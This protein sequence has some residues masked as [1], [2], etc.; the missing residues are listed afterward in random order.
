MYNSPGTYGAWR[1]HWIFWSWSYRQ[2]QDADFFQHTE[3]RTQALVISQQV[4]L[5]TMP[6]L[7]LSVCLW[8][9][10]H[11]WSFIK[12][13]TGI[14]ILGIRNICIST[15]YALLYCQMFFLLCFLEDPDYRLATLLSPGTFLILSQFP[16]WPLV[17]SIS[18]K[19]LITCFQTFKFTFNLK[20]CL[21]T[22]A[23]A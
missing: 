7:Q 5:P 15:F 1:G 9:P 12:I 13:V 4:L 3:I 8:C 18:H 21:A 22:C 19:T 11:F 2:S 20:Y 10:Q 16:V 23:C 14:C 17:E 6:A